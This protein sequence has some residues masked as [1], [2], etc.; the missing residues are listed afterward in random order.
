MNAECH[1]Q[2]ENF[3]DRIKHIKKESIKLTYN[4]KKERRERK[5]EY[6]HNVQ[7]TTATAEVCDGISRDKSERERFN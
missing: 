1:A 4:N 3:I 5:R 7:C 6:F 2:I